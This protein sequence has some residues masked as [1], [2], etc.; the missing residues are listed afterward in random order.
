MSGALDDDATEG[1]TGLAGSGGVVAV[2]NQ[3]LEPTA[4][5][6]RSA[7]TSGAAHRQR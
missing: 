4:S 7:P 6:V 1:T 2:P 5:S 3:A